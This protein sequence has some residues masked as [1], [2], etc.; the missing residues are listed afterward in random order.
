[1]TPGAR[2][3]A[4]LGLRPLRP[5]MLVVD[6]DGSRWTLLGSPSRGRWRLIGIDGETRPYGEWTWI[7][8][9]PDLSD[10]ATRGALLDVLREV[11]G[12]DGLCVHRIYTPDGVCYGF[13]GGSSCGLTAIMAPTEAEALAAAA[14]ALAP[15]VPR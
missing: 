2:V 15:K 9:T 3:V 12:D 8:L 5:R 6:S 4:A 13:D 11:S 14:E 7:T 10:P 1:M